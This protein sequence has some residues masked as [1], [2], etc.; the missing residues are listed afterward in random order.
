MLERQEGAWKN[1]AF[2]S[3]NGLRH[4]EEVTDLMAGGLDGFELRLLIPMRA[5]G[6]RASW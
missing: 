4:K 2:D 3:A 1:Q 6:E 5:T